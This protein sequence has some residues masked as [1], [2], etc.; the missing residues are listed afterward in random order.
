M[1][2]IIEKTK[3]ITSDEAPV[4]E[5]GVESVPS[6]KAASKIDKIVKRKYEKEDLIPCKSITNGKLFVEG[7]K[8]DILYRWADYGDVDYVEYQDLIYM[9]R[10][11]KSWVFKPR[12]IIMDDEFVQQTPEIKKLYDSL[13]SLS[14]LRE[15]LDLPASQMKSAILGLPDGAKDAIKGVASSQIEHG[16]L[17]SVQKIKILDEIFGTKL[18]LALSQE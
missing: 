13:Y 11:R 12:F 17:D 3:N 14:D 16:M 18:L 6:E 1:A 5:V 10:S 7:S 15:I 9:V 2:K 8:S 4:Q